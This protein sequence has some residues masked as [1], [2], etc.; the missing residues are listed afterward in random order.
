MLVRARCHVEALSLARLSQRLIKEVNK[1]PKL[2]TM[3]K[4]DA[5][6]LLSASNIYIESS[7]HFQK[8]GVNFGVVLVSKSPQ[9]NACVS[10]DRAFEKKLRCASSVVACLLFGLLTLAVL[11]P[12]IH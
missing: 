1:K 2:A 12:P 10:C 4:R 6:L 8:P 7:M 11:A 5:D 9:A 3:W